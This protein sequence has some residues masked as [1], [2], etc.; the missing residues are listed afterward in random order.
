MAEK[1]CFERLNGHLIYPE[2][3]EEMKFLYQ[4]LFLKKEFMKK[5]IGLALHIDN[6]YRYS[7][8]SFSGQDAFKVN[9]DNPRLIISSDQKGEICYPDWTW[10]KTK[11]YKIFEKAMDYFDAKETCEGI[12]NTRL[13]SFSN[14]EEFDKLLNGYE[15]KI[16]RFWTSLVR[17]RG[18]WSWIS[19][20]PFNAAKWNVGKT[21]YNRTCGLLNRNGAVDSTLCTEK[22]SFI[23][24]YNSNLHLSQNDMIDK[25]LCKVYHSTQEF[26]QKLS[27]GT[28]LEERDEERDDTYCPYRWLRVNE[29]CYKLFTDEVSWD[30]A[31]KLCETQN[32]M[33]AVF[34]SDL[35]YKNVTSMIGRNS[36]WFGLRYINKKL[37]WSDNK[38]HNI[39]FP[40]RE[41]FKYRKCF[42]GGPIEN[43][44]KPLESW[45]LRGCNEQLSYMCVFKPTAHCELG[46]I[47][48]RR[49]CYA[50]LPTSRLLIDA[51]EIC[52]FKGSNVLWLDSKEEENFVLE[53]ALTVGK[54]TVWIG[55]KLYD[56]QT[57][58]S[59]NR[60]VVYTR[61][62]TEYE[63]ADFVEMKN[64]YV[65]TS[66]AGW[67]ITNENEISGVICKYKKNFKRPSNKLTM[68]RRKRIRY[69]LTKTKT[70]SAYGTLKVVLI[71]AFVI[72]ILLISITG[73][74]TIRQLQKSVILEAVYD[75]VTKAEH[76]YAIVNRDHFID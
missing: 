69:K 56:N 43:V 22:H 72:G 74:I 71:I 33:L 4:S 58:W 38:G 65:I 36:F 54:P 14:R 42:S 28:D 19:H 63:N 61:W 30:E 16:S 21:D 68:R 10:I 59:N 49:H 35:M 75:E 51:E 34:D 32:S 55:M 18:K 15:T 9:N 53:H 11:C 44:D 73:Y 1:F 52:M 13:A 6:L 57:Y 50:F 7:D 20:I 12:R 5:R 60:K 67:S 24:E 26:K 45:K 8:L 47:E 2:N 25:L 23:C 70:S 17:H 41:D 76:E 48:Y 40:V 27:Q 39:H 64:L 62:K 66:S 29:S 46:F 37:M 31:Q 3:D